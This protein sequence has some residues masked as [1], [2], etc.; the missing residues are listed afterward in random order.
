MMMTTIRSIV[1]LAFFWALVVPALAEEAPSSPQK[2]GMATG[3]LSEKLVN[4]SPWRFTTQYENTVHHFRFS[5]DGKLQRMSS[6]NPDVWKDFPVSETQTA[7][8][9]T[10]NG[11]VIEFALGADGSPTATHSKYVSQFKSIKSQLE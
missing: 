7:S 3:G 5:S 10:K 2:V 1:C 11:H 4:G 8:Y 9:G 6:S